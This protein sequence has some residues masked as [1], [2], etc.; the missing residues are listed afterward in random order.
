M[1]SQRDSSR[2]QSTRVR[3]KRIDPIV[4]SMFSVTSSPT[5][6]Q[7]RDWK[8]KHHTPCKADAFPP[9]RDD[10]L[11]SEKPVTMTKPEKLGYKWLDLPVSVTA[12]RVAGG[13]QAYVAR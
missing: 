6:H 9:Q 3:A 2:K 12:G 5:G 10:G 7:R 4:S 13:V 8:A 11:V 1:R